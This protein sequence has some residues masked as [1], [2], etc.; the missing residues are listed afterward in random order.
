MCEIMRNIQAKESVKAAEIYTHKGIITLW[1]FLLYE[2]GEIRCL[3][4]V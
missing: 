4:K 2:Q 3:L 1:V